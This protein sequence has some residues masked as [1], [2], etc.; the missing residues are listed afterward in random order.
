MTPV[1]LAKTP[2]ASDSPITEPRTWRRLA[3]MARN[4]AISRRRCATTIENVL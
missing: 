2:T 3:P 4:S 1:V